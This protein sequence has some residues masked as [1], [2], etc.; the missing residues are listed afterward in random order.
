MEGNADQEQVAELTRI[1]AAFRSECDMLC[2]EFEAIHGSA[3]VETAGDP[4]AGESAA[5]A[6]E[7]WRRWRKAVEQAPQS[8][9]CLSGGGIRSATFSLGVV[10]ALA[11]RGWLS[12]FHYLSTV[13]GGGYLGSFISAWT[14]RERFK[15]M[16]EGLQEPVKAPPSQINSPIGN[17][18]AYDPVNAPNGWRR[19]VRLPGPVVLAPGQLLIV[20]VGKLIPMGGL[21]A[22]RWPWKARPEA[23][24]EAMPAS[25]SVP[26]R[27]K[28]ELDIDHRS[29]DVP[30][31]GGMPSY[32]ADAWLADCVAP[33]PDPSEAPASAGADAKAPPP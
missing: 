18:R 20:D 13:S 22:R 12:D 4:G 27:L 31:E 32:L 6:S 3:P 17:L 7:Q 16:D 33:R 23:A 8:A 24:S 10:Q 9:L 1:E 25:C 14:S 26:L 15:A 11:K 28:V 5:D 30:I 19:T 29:H 21:W 2:A